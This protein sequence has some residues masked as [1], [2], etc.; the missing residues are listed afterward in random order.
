MNKHTYQLWGSKLLI[1]LLCLTPAIWIFWQAA[2]NQLGADPVKAMLHFYGKGALHCLFATLLITPLQR[3]FRHPLLLKNRRLLGL[4]SFFYAA[5][6]LLTYL[7]F[8][9]QWEWPTFI[10][11]LLQRSYISVG[12][13][14]WL[15]LALLA[16]TS[17][18]LIR[19]KMGR[20]WMRLHAW[21]YPATLA[22]TL[23]YFWAEKFSVGPPLLYLLAALLLLSLRK[24]RLLLWLRGH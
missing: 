13:F 7:W 19:V 23:H 17:P 18:Q 16:L 5:L 3:R 9:L 21:I 12:M 11:D 1:H 15:V 8:E 14:A 10:E 2:N 4:Y 6:H 24:K 22:A 20:H